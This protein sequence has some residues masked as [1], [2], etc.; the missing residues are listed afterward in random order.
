MMIYK[1]FSLLLIMVWLL[2]SCN[3]E[4]TKEGLTFKRLRNGGNGIVQPGQYLLMHVVAVDENDSTWFDTRVKDQPALVRVDP[5]NE[6]I[7]E[8]GEV[9][10]YRMLGKGDSVTFT[11]SVA[12]IYHETWLKPVPK[13][14]NPKMNVDYF[15]S[16]VD[17]FNDQTLAEYQKIQEEKLEQWRVAHQIEQFGKDTVLIDNHLKAK[18]IQAKKTTSGIRYEVINEGK[19]KPIGRG[20]VVMVRYTGR[21]LNG[22][23]FDS[24][25]NAKEPFQVVVGA[26]QVISG[27]EEMLMQM[28]LGSKYIVY[29]PSLFGYGDRNIPGIPMDSI[30][31]FE[32]EVVKIL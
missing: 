22:T 6:K 26:N 30:L 20:S 7:K 29:L 4:Q 17:V 16:V 10:V 18:A 19:G 25:L 8:K 23:V 24:N 1:R 27:W 11:V 9:G 5:F 21:F 31:I 15:I 14:L 2:T 32:I 12:T 28:T 3:T 13:G